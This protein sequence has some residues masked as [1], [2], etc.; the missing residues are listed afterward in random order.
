MTHHHAANAI[1]A[2]L[3]EF[4]VRS[5]IL[6]DQIVV[7]EL[8]DRHLFV[9]IDFTGADSGKMLETTEHPGALQAAHVNRCVTKHF[10]RR[11][12]KRPRI[13]TVRK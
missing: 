8:N 2:A 12:P 4:D 3:K 13:E 10:A 5:E 11:P 1:V 7:R 9:R 6:S